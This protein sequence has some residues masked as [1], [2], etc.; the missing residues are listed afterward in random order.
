MD[1]KKK[2]IRYQTK[3]SWFRILIRSKIVPV[4]NPDQTLFLDPATSYGSNRILNLI[5]TKSYLFS[6][7]FS[8]SFEKGLYPDPHP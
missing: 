3:T 2:K 5:P 4:T 1:K 8:S 6:Q 7:I